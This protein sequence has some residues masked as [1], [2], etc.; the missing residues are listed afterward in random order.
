MTAEE[1]ERTIEKRKEAIREAAYEVRKT[2]R[3]LHESED[4]T[5]AARKTLRRAGLLQPS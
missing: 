1:L 3:V 5:T 2:E 4:K